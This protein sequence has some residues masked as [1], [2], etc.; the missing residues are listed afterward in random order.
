MKKVLSLT[1][2]LF[3][4]VTATLGISAG[5]LVLP[6]GTGRTNYAEPGTL[7]L[8]HTHSSQ[9][10]T[11]VAQYD[12]TQNAIIL[13]QSATGYSLAYK[14]LSSLAGQDYVLTFSSNTR[15]WSNQWYATVQ[16]AKNNR[17]DQHITFG[18][19]GLNYYDVLGDVHQLVGTQMNSYSGGN[20]FSLTIYVRQTG[21]D[22][23]D[24]AFYFN[25][26]LIDTFKDQPK[27]T[28]YLKFTGSNGTNN[29]WNPAIKNL[30]VYTSGI[31]LGDVNGDGNVTPADATTFGRYLAN[32]DGVTV[33]TVNADVNEDGQVTPLDLV[34]LRRYLANWG[35]YVMPYAPTVNVVTKGVDNTGETDV[36]SQ[37][38]ALHATG[39]KVYYPN[40]TYLFNGES[41]N[42][43][44]G[45]QFESMDGVLIR[46]SISDAPV[47]VFDD[48]GNLIGL[49]QNH[50]EKEYGE[51]TSTEMANTAGYKTFAAQVR[52]EM[53][54]STGVYFYQ[55]TTKGY[56]LRGSFNLAGESTPFVR[57]FTRD[58]QTSTNDVG[59][60]YNIAVYE[61]PDATAE[62]SANPSLVVKGLTPIATGEDFELSGSA[63]FTTS[64]NGTLSLSYLETSIAQLPDDKQ[65]LL[66][67]K[68][69]AVVF[70][71]RTPAH[72]TGPYWNMVLTVA[73]SR[74]GSP[75]NFRV[76]RG[77]D[78]NT[79]YE[80]PLITNGKLVSPPISVA[81]DHTIADVLPYWYNDFGCA[82]KVLNPGSGAIAWYDWSWNHHDCDGDPYDP[83]R[84]PLLGF[85]YG[86]DPVTLDW[87][88]YWLREYGINQAVLL[89]MASDEAAD[90]ANGNH[91]IYQLLNNV[92]NARTMKFAFQVGFSYGWTYAQWLEQF[93]LLGETF[94]FNEK[95]KDMA[96]CYVEDNKRY[97]V[98]TLY[99]ME[100]I[101]YCL[102]KASGYTTL[103]NSK[104]LFAEV[105]SMYKDHGYDGI[106]V[107][108]RYP[109]A[110]AGTVST[111]T[112]ANMKS[113]DDV[114][115]FYGEYGS[116]TS[117]GGSTY[118]ER[119]D[120]YYV[121]DC[122][123]FVPALCT[124]MHSNV[125]HSSH[126]NCPGSTPAL[127]QSWLGKVVNS[128]Q[129]NSNCK[130]LI[131]VYNIA[132][133][134]E[135][136]PGL[137]PNMQDRFAYL[138]A[139]RNTVCS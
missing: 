120:H 49:Q 35:G 46:N 76:Y 34:A 2:A 119:V 55:S 52:R 138:D 21:I 72:Q 10:A 22:L 67:G 124:S 65:A 83:S 97:A 115:F 92:P 20:G 39:K 89:G 32:W 6:S 132:E 129:T 3:L 84:H 110:G 43:S 111:T 17:F 28:P 130:K 74:S 77:V 61:V 113:Q 109:N 79:V 27:L 117:N 14:D 98:I 100:A 37:L 94:Y 25:G 7:T 48:K 91:W 50:L 53:D 69:Y 104:A 134:A 5:A 123:N 18:D 38:I 47:V 81:D 16:F 1:L 95:Y 54:G 127:F 41:L 99:D 62:T 135:G 15:G 57:F 68:S 112:I 19:R 75:Q 108:A 51:D 102:E 86:D 8:S 24:I 121:P 90:P 136:G 11:N 107:I 44:G 60:F 128:I 88:C 82:T 71:K 131:T 101:R 70:A 63:A 87:Q 29:G 59:E 114:L 9:L 66:E 96:Y 12:S 126:W 45:V 42:F 13:P 64:N 36:T 103:P 139:V 93:E 78:L 30:K 122:I 105:S 73:R 31:K 33:N 106:C 23:V 137:Q 125:A 26:T 58:A 118:A 85:Y 116:N 4:L 40:G 56:S 80:S 133:W